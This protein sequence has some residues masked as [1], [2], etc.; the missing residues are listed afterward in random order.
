MNA[1]LSDDF[2]SM[3][4][5]PEKHVRLKTL[6]IRHDQTCHAPIFTTGHDYPRNKSTYRQRSTF[7]LDLLA[8]LHSWAHRFGLQRLESTIAIRVILSAIV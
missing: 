6:I 4:S 7:D 1:I 5:L 2:T 3:Q 8:F